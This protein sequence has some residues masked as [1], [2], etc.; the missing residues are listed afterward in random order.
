MKVIIIAAIARNRVIG[1]NGK[2]PWHIPEDLQRFKRITTGHTVIMGRKT[3][4]SLENPLPNRTIVVITSRAINGVKSYPSLEYA[5]EVLKNEPE[6]YVIGG[7]R[8]FSDALKYADELQLTLIEKEVEGDTYFPPYQ[9]MLRSNFQLV[10]EQR[11]A[12]FSFMD[13]KRKR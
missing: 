3:Y 2:L 10:Q 4:D 8:V 6:V 7:G 1:K 11:L 12:G 5:L 13:Y 9:E